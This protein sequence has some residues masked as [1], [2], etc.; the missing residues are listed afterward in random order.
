MAHPMTTAFRA[1]V[2]AICFA[3]C[4]ATM[5]LLAR[6]AQIRWTVVRA[7]IWLIILALNQQSKSPWMVQ[8]VWVVLLMAMFFLI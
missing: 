4:W 2:V 3:A 8:A 1:M 6:V 7:T 5:C